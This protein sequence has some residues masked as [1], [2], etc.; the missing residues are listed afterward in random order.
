MNKLNPT[1]LTQLL[2]KDVCPH[3]KVYSD[4]KD[5]S[6]SNCSTG[7]TICIA[8]KQ[9]YGKRDYCNYNKQSQGSHCFHPK[10]GKYFGVVFTLLDIHSSA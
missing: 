1:T 5:F 2:E 4:R 6:D 3:I 10:L 8:C 7:R 9:E